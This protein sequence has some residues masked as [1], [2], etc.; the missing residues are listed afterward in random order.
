MSSSND[1]IEALLPP[2]EVARRLGV[3]PETLRRLRL[4][5]DGP[6]VCR[7]GGRWRYPSDALRR[8]IEA[9]TRGGTERAEAPH[10]RAA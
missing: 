7:I 5:G 4:A 2:A 1:P 10:G 6:P 8:W 9:G 3:H